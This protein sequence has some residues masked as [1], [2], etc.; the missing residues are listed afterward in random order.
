VVDDVVGSFARVVVPFRNPPFPCTQRMA[1]A[2]LGE[3][4]PEGTS[5]FSED[6]KQCGCIPWGALGMTINRRELSV[7]NHVVR[8]SPSPLLLPRTNQPPPYALPNT[9]VPRHQALLA[10]GL[11]AHHDRQD[12]LH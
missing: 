8:P 9:G 11:D 4:L 10:A 3:E 7:D 12:Q 6:L 1:T 5:N 2:P